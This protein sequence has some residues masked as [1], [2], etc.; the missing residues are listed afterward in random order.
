MISKNKKR[1]MIS[2]PHSTLKTLEKLRPLLKLKT[3]SEV[4]DYAINALAYS[5]IELVNNK[6]IKKE[7]N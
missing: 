6:Y 3:D 7:K 2:L 4:I 1:V 5:V